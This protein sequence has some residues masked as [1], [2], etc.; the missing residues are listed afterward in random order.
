METD[1]QFNTTDGTQQTT[2]NPQSNVGGNL[3]RQ[4]PSS[5]Q[6]VPGQTNLDQQH[7]PNVNDL[8]VTIT[9]TPNNTTTISPS[10][11]TVS[12]FSSWLWLSA[13]LLIVIVIAVFRLRKDTEE[14]AIN[15]SH[16]AL[17]KPNRRKSTKKRK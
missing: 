13:L 12:P 6:P 2:Q 5:L 9:S 16:T 4:N 17:S 10:D 7:L 3:Q 14:I 11:N 1:A 8:N 15:D